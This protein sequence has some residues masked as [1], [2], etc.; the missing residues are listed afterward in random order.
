MSP[1]LPRRLSPRA[2]FAVDYGPLI[3]FFVVYFFGRKLAP[4]VGG[5]IGRDIAIAPGQELFAAVAAFLPSFAIAFLYS[6]LRERRIAPMLAVSGVAV[7]VLGVL[8]LF[9]RD[10][11]FFYMKPTI[12]YAMFAVALGGGVA[13]GRNPLK[14]LFDGA[15]HL[16]E[17]VWKTLTKRYAVFFIALAL[18]NEIAWRYLTRDCDLSGAAACAGEPAWVNLKLIGFTG[19]NIVF[20]LL[21]TPLLAKHLETPSGGSGSP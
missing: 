16:P 14:A 1:P 11:T 2:K 18:A 6:T 10:K 7:G 13:A 8:T 19:A 20:A 12:V 5:V 9:L 4:I 15:L 17:D 3:A 21:Q